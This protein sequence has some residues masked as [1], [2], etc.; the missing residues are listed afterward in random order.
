MPTAIAPKHAQLVENV[1]PVPVPSKK[2]NRGQ[3]HHATLIL[4]CRPRAMGNR[5]TGR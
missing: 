5:P 2:A 3:G 1:L 4:L